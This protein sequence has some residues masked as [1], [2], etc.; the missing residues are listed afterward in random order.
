VSKI[1]EQKTF[2]AAALSLLIA[3]AASGAE[4]LDPTLPH[5]WVV[6]SPRG[7]APMVRLD[8]ERSGRAPEALPRAPRVL[9]RSRVPGGIAHPVTVDDQ[10]ALIVS[11]PIAALTQIAAGGK[12]LWTVQT[13]A[14][15]PVTAPVLTSDGT[16]VVLT[17]GGDLLGFDRAGRRRFSVLLP[18]A[19]VRNVAEPLPLDDGGLVVAG[20][21][22]VLRLDR[23]GSLQARALLDADVTVLLSRGRATLI[24]TERGDVAE[25]HPP[26]A[27]TKIASFAGR[28]DGAARFGSTLI[29]VVDQARLIDLD[30]VTGARHERLEMP[31]G[32]SGWPSLLP[33]GGTRIVTLDGLLL[34]HDSRAN[35][36]QRVALEPPTLLGSAGAPSAPASASP[37]VIVD[38]KGRVGFV[39]PGLAAGVV[40]ASGTIH[41]AEGAACLDPVGVTP[42][43]LG[44]MVLACRSGALWMLGER[45]RGGA[46]APSAGAP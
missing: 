22:S 10:G 25:W 9:W 5:A 28:V 36:T 39:R 21:R 17:S 38:A 8:A 13:G 30:L 43:G 6:G 46:S 19:A 45:P 32:L 37:S 1:S 23:G 11:S 41:S 16:R 4:R 26:S 34:G 33:D 42:A 29:A 31:L 15:P 27:P 14:T 2:V 24:I 44:R 3:G 35:E 40:D 12:T 20:G 18:L 7:A